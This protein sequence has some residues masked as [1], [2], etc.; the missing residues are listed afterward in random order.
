MRKL[1]LVVVAAL[2]LACSGG[3][4]PAPGAE[5]QDAKALV[6]AAY[7]RNAAAKTVHMSVKQT[8]S[9]AG[10]TQTISQET[11]M[12]LPRLA[13][14][15]V[16]SGGISFEMVMDGV[17]A[18]IKTPGLPWRSLAE[19]AGVSLESLGFSDESFDMTVGYSK[20]I[21]SAEFLGTVEEKGVAVKRIKAELD[22]RGIINELTRILTPGSPLA[23]LYKSARDVKGS[24]EYSI[25][26][27]DGR[28]HR[29]YLTLTL[30][31]GSQLLTSEAEAVFSRFDEP[32]SFPSDSP[33]VF[34]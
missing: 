26:E 19:V 14:A 28:I 8:S 5:Q 27:Q 11:D 13:Y 6:V 24:A 16:T 32:L 1:A 18:Y 34:R 15:R 25:G 9:A 4:A 10:Q 23:D 21:A 29:V 20:T 22:G 12:L 30:R 2:S 31:I 3:D 7:E 33:I 17:H